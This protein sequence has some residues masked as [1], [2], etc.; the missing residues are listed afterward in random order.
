MGNA[1]R[2]ESDDKHRRHDH[3]GG[4][5]RHRRAHIE[6]QLRSHDRPEPARLREKPGQLR[7]PCFTQVDVIQLRARHRALGIMA[8][9]EPA[10]RRL[11]N[12][13]RHLPSKKIAIAVA[14][15][16]APEAFDSQGNTR[17]PGDTIFRW[18]GTDLAPDD[19]P[20]VPAPK[21][22]RQRVQLRM[23]L[24]NLRSWRPSK[25]IGNALAARHRFQ[26]LGRRLGCQGRQLHRCLRR[27]RS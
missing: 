17:I 19:A 6:V 1:D 11:R 25:T 23:R 15:T 20:P 27:R 22:T 13:E 26:R 10:P 12:K 7:A 24:F 3:D 14:V 9:A 16:F 5:S 21:S 8:I 2:R 18:I 4:E